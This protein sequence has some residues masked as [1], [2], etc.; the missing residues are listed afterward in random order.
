MALCMS[1]CIRKVDLMLNVLIQAQTEGH[2]D[3]QEGSRCVYDLE[4]GHDL[5]CGDG[6]MGICIYENSSN[7][8][9]ICAF[10]VYEL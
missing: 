6:I 2:E 4:C 1:R 7:Y 5:D 10:F 3:T 9:K 8:T